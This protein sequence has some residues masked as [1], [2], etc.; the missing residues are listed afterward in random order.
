[1]ARE[2]CGV[3][4]LL[5]HLERDIEAAIREVE[6][7]GPVALESYRK[8]LDERIQAILYE[9]VDQVLEVEAVLEAHPAV[10]EAAVVPIG[11]PTT[12]SSIS[13]R[14]VISRA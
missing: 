12:V 4:L 3:R 6:A 10:A 7:R 14:R 1:M 8:R 2:H 13:W 11:V 5:E 9:D